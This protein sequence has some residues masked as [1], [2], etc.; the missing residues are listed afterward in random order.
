MCVRARR[1]KGP[2]KGGRERAG[3]RE[4]GTWAGGRA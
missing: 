1:A 3:G 2:T 4:G